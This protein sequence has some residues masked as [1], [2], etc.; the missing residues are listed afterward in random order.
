MIYTPNLNKLQNATTLQNVAYLLEIKPSTLS[1]HLYI[2][3]T[4]RDNRNTSKYEEFEIPKKSGGVRRIL[5][6][7]KDLK[8]IQSKLL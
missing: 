3:G 1:Y 4:D 6:P 5:A 7:N 8:S 2:L